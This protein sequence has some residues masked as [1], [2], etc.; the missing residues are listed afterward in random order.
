MPRAEREVTVTDGDG[1]VCADHRGLDMCGCVIIDP[2]VTV[3]IVP[4]YDVAKLVLD[5]SRDA[6][7]AVF[8]DPDG[9]RRVVDE[10]MGDAVRHADFVRDGVRDVYGFL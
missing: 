1:H 4:R 6:A 7:I 5:V 10:D 9:A 2:V 3:R 8:I